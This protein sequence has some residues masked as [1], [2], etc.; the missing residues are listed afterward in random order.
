VKGQE[1]KDHMG[2]DIYNDTF[3][4]KK[5]EYSLAR[6]YTN[7]SGEVLQEVGGYMVKSSKEGCSITKMIGQ[8]LKKSISHFAKDSTQELSNPLQ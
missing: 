1:G 6:P 2:G 8:Y 5:V 7:K 3:I 4:K